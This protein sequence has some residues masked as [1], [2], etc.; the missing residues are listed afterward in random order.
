[1][2]CDSA[3]L[4]VHLCRPDGRDLD[5]TE[6]AELEAHLAHCPECRTLARNRQRLDAHLG[7]AMLAVEVPRDLKA[8]IVNRLAADRGERYRRRL[9]G[10]VR[11]LAAA[12]A[13]LL[14]AWGWYAFYRPALPELAAEEVFI[15]FNVSR[16]ARDEVNDQ[17]RRLGG[18]AGAPA[19]VD[20]AYLTGAPA[21]AVLPGT[22]DHK[23]PV[24]APQLIFTRGEQRVVVYILSSR[25]YQVEELNNPAHGYTYRLEVVR[26]E[27]EGDF[28]YLILHTGDSWD[29]LR[30]PPATT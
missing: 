4:C 3:R 17:L 7:R 19:F 6:A 1:M 14:L 28:V 21:L 26:A 18:R 13:V 22:Q 11:G 30:L 20:Y 25:Q 2:D 10:V 12:A 24:Q 16:P 29:W 5:G 23:A 8:R 9:R 15:S 27:E